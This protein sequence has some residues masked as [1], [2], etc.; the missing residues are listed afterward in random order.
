MKTFT[1]KAGDIKRKWYLM[2]AEGLVLGRMATRVATILR[3]KD[4][5]TYAPHL[6]LGD[7]VIVINAEKVILT[8]RK[9]DQKTY[10][11]HTM[12][13]GGL[14]AVPYRKLKAEHPEQI[15]E[16]AIRGMIPHTTLGRHILQKLHIYAGP[17]HPHTAQQPE[18][19]H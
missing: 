14:K 1:P 12:Y 17:E 9:E 7:N 18:L 8:G 15:V 16:R 5:P 4:K 10:H 3:G 13:P 11:Y 2:N 6:D 19:L